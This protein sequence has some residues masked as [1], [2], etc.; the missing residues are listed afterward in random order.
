MSRAP[1]TRSR[2]G[3]ST[4]RSLRDLSAPANHREEGGYDVRKLEVSLCVQNR[5]DEKLHHPGVAEAHA[6]SGP[7]LFCR[8][9]AGPG[10]FPREGIRG[11]KP[12]SLEGARIQSAP[13]QPHGRLHA[14]PGTDRRTDESGWDSSLRRSNLDNLRLAAGAGPDRRGLP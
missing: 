8:R 13:V 2:E 1:D 3:L 6:G 11:S 9:P 14:V 10:A 4:S 12:E 5:R 7:D